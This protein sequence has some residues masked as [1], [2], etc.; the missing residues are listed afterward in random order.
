MWAAW[1]VD[2]YIVQKVGR[3]ITTQ[4]A[5]WCHGKEQA[6]SNASYTIHALF[7]DNYT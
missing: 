5:S 4:P 7:K 3:I 6:T 2:I 1:C